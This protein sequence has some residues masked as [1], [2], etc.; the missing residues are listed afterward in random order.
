M[1]AVV[2]AQLDEATFQ[3]TWAKGRALALEQA[4]AQALDEQESPFP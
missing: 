2:R 1:I 3:S 4:I